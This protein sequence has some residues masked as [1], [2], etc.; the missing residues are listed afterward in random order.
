MGKQILMKKDAKIAELEREH[1]DYFAE[2]TALQ[3]V[4]AE[5]EDTRSPSMPSMA[6]TIRR[7]SRKRRRLDEAGHA[8][9]VVEDSNLMFSGVNEDQGYIVIKNGEQQTSLSG[10]YLTTKSN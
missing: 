4:I 3:K 9:E 1:C 7:E 6:D 10:F 5:A 8:A 2:I